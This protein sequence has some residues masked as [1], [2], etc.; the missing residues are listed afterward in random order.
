MTVSLV[1]NNL[2]E[3]FTEVHLAENLATSNVMGK[4]PKMGKRMYIKLCLLIKQTIVPD[5][6]E[7]SIGFWSKMPWAI[8]GLAHHDEGTSKQQYQ[9]RGL[10]LSGEHHS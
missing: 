6:P 4:I 10:D 7:G 3:P 2:V 5:R 8:A 1:N 9:K